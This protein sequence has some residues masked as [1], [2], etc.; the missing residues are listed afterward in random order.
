VDSFEWNKIAGWVLAAAVAM[1]GLTILTGYVYGPKPLEKQAYEV[2]GVEVEAEGGTAEA[3]KPIA[4]Y[5]QTA[6]VQKG[7]AQ[8]KKCAACHSIEKG[9]ANGIGPNLWGVKGKTHAHMPGFDYSPALLATKSQVWD[10]ESMDKWLENPRGYIP[11]NKMSF[12]GLGKPQDRADLLVYLNSKSDSPQPLPP[13][14]AA[15]VAA[16]ASAQGASPAEKGA[17]ADASPDAAQPVQPVDKTA[18]TIKPGNAT[19]P[20]VLTPRKEPTKSG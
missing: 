15:E 16:P 13:P 3:A 7:E 19:A 14:P 11:G 9:A 10:W 12:A 2:Q 18:E 1:L 6:N 20:I 17:P 8:F 4:F 5:L